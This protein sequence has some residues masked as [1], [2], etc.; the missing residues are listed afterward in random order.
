MKSHIFFILLIILASCNRKAH[1]QNPF[2]GDE[3][4]LP[5]YIEEC[6]SELPI[7]LEK[8]AVKKALFAHFERKGIPLKEKYLY[9]D[10]NISFLLDGYNAEKKIGYIWITEAC[11]EMDAMEN[12]IIE[13]LKEAGE[14]K[15]YGNQDSL[16]F[17]QNIDTLEQMFYVPPKVGLSLTEVKY[18]LD[19]QEKGE[20]FIALINHFDERYSLFDDHLHKIYDKPKNK[21][22]TN[23]QLSEHLD[24][25]EQKRLK[26]RQKALVR[27]MN[28]YYF[29]SRKRK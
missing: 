12:M 8:A 26:Q 10:E 5:Y 3:L 17:Y 19:K 22:K 11:L 24:K 23:G 15:M 2:T 14:F 25:I 27:D 7:I 20:V 16:S 28:I 29:W 18:I 6:G 9:E 21:R 4:Y 13:D 1:L